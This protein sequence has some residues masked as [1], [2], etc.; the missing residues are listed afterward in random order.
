LFVVAYDAIRA[1]SDLSDQARLSF[2]D[3]LIVWR[4]RSLVRRLFTPKILNDGLDILGV[5][6]TNPFAA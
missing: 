1:A 3:A 6:I 5:R 4:Q 2:W